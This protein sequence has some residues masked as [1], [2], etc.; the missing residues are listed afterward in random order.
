MA[1]INL[2]QSNQSQGSASSTSSLLNKIGI[3]IL[4]VVVLAYGF[5]LISS[6]SHA[7]NAAKLAQQKQAIEIQIEQAKE[8]PELVLYQNKLYNVKLLLQNHLLWSQILDKFAAATLK[9]AKFDKFIANAD[10][11][12]T[13]SGFV[14][15]FA[16]L[17]KQ[18]KA[19]QLNDFQYIK[20]VRLVNVG[21]SSGE[22]IGIDFT[23]KVVFNT[24]LLKN[25]AASTAI[26][27]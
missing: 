19:Y 14:P 8:Y 3:G 18:I 10:G 22:R 4:V 11:T 15:D 7:K 17:D 1:E 9:T 6:G 26:N 13:I 23:L 16:S 21:L 12:A 25:N 2:L 5:F 20:D 24:S 27:E